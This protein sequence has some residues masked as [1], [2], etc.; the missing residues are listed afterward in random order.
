MLPVAVAASPAAAKGAH[1]ADPF[2]LGVASGDPLADRVVLWTRLL[3][4][5][6]LP[7]RAIPVSWQVAHDERLPPDGPRRPHHGPP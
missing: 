1:A 6:P 4:E 3:R 5:T 2:P 7:S